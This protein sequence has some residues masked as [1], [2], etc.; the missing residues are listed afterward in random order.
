M[1]KMGSLNKIAWIA[2][3]LVA[4]AASFLTV[5][6]KTDDGVSLQTV[7][8][9]E[10]KVVARAIDFIEK[11]YVD[12]PAVNAGKMLSE[13]AKELVRSI[14]PLLVKEKPKEMTVTM[15]DKKLVLPSSSPVSLDELPVLLSQ[16]LGFLDLFYKGR[17]DDQERLN[18]AMMGVADTLDP[19][20]NYLSPKV[21]NEFKI[22]TKGNFGGLGIVIGFRDGDL[23]VIAPLE[24]TPA[25][26]AGIKAKD[27]IVQIGGESTIN[28]GLTEA[29]EKLRGPVGSKVS[30]VIT[31]EDAPDPLKFTLTRALIRIQS[32][33]GRLLDGLEGRPSPAGGR[34]GLVKI[35]NFQEDTIEQFRKTL[36]SF[37]SGG[38]RIEGLILDLRNN[39]GG[40]L[41]QAV[42]LS[43]F[44]L[45]RGVIVKTVGARGEVLEVEKAAPGD[46]GEK[47]PLVVIV[48]ENSA[49]AS[50]IVAGSLQY[51]DR[52]VVIGNRSFGKG[53][54]QTVFDLKDGSALKLTIAK[55]LT[56]KDYAVQSKGINPD[57]GLI[58][59]TVPAKLT[60]DKGKFTKRVDLFE[61]VKKRELELEEQRNGDPDSEEEHKNPNLPPPPFQMTYLAPDRDR[62]EEG[63]DD[64]N[65]GKIDLSGDFPVAMAA[66]LLGL[67]L[68]LGQ[69]M[70]PEKA[71]LRPSVLGA[72]P[73]VL[74]ELQK[75]QKAK[76]RL[77]LQAL[78]VDWSSGKK[79]GKPAGVVTS[80]LL[81]EQEKP[82]EGLA[83]GESGFLRVTVEN[84]GSAP[85]L[86]LAA[87]TK[88]DD[89]LFANIEFPF[90]KVAPGEKRV[91]K[92]P[93]KI[94]DF[95][96]RRKVPVEIEFHEAFA[97]LPKADILS[98]QVEE[99]EA[100][101]FEYSYRVI[102]NGSQGTKGNGNGK[103][104]K[105]ETIALAVT[106]KNGGKGESKAPAVNLKKVEGDETFIEK[107][108]EELKPI[109]AGGQAEVTLKF[110]VPENLNGKLAFDLS[111]HDMHLGEDLS[112]RLDFSG[113]P[114]SASPPAQN[115]LQAPPVISLPDNGPPLA[116]SGESYTLKGSA[117]DD[118]E[119]RHL[120]IFVGDNKVFY[121]APEK[122]SKTLSFETTLPLKKGANLITLAA[123]DD[124]EL[125]SRKQWI[126]WR[127]K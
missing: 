104:E 29:V 46:G 6:V 74:E 116:S 9:K 26:R 80:E 31:R 10:M 40:L 95:V 92:T 25:D 60:D 91:W 114:E 63:G 94:P 43:D 66:R 79:E 117:T 51:N 5:R 123:Q 67:S 112:D 115:T 33:A 82:R 77:A 37:E 78:Q 75:D 73:P 126:V 122:P 55:Y 105:G 3:L 103:V 21:F 109:P 61:N 106:V 71:V 4:G 113:T 98:L 54:V 83:A 59:A 20:S 56:A 81:D 57:V 93:L 76:I 44:F 36:R 111:I 13:A 17:V 89:P 42:A 24:G 87:V 14:P 7:P 45:S 65:A 62:D 23:S 32:V 68:N 100:P 85:F 34:F 16:I 90:G 50:E 22:G 96:H 110:R 118:I 30:I 101:L 39:P 8:L 125:T 127:N 69:Y 58:P 18:L 49:S 52:A 120:F 107:G 28:M 121:Q 27:K 84:R 88:S 70:P 35:K 64:D 47:I 72:L 1:E 108:R 86:Q 38:N 12:P 102:D 124:R 53:S 99:P 119:L 11:N 41:D 19:H 97:R 48:N 2:I 15:G